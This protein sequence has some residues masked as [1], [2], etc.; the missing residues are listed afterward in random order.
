MLNIV[1]LIPARGGSKGI[2]LKALQP[3]NRTSMIDYS[4]ECAVNSVCNETYISTDSSKIKD[5]VQKVWKDLVTVIDRPP[6]FATDTASI[7]SVIGHFTKMVQ[8]D[9]LVLLQCTSPMTATVNLN[10]AIGKFVDK[11]DMYDSAMSVFGLEDNDLLLWRNE[12][13]SFLTPINYD[14]LDRGRRQNRLYNTHYIETGAFYM[15]TRKQ[16]IESNCRIGARVLPIITP[17]WSSFEIDDWNDLYYVEKL[18][19]NGN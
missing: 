15:T 7:E 17:F 6:E 4:I 12:P 9:I 10:S 14:P 8:Y 16:F 11:L 3:L 19:K 1:S 5:H 2:P 13:G 18:M